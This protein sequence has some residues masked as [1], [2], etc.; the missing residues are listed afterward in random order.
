MSPHVGDAFSEVS[1]CRHGRNPDDSDAI[2]DIQPPMNGPE[3]NGHV[4]SRD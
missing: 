3:Q 1:Q 2:D 4:E